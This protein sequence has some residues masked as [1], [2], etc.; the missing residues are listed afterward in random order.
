M[1]YVELTG[2]AFKMFLYLLEINV[3]LTLSWS[4]IT[5]V[6][7]FVIPINS[8]IKKEVP[9]AALLGSWLM[10]LYELKG[11]ILKEFLKG[12]AYFTL[13]FLLVYVATSR[14]LAIYLP[15]ENTRLKLIALTAYSTV[16]AIYLYFPNLYKRI[17]QDLEFKEVIRYF[18]F[19]IA[20][21]LALFLSLVVFPRIWQ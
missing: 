1:S 17:P 7:D 5:F 20:S 11:D 4:L 6:R 19:E 16:M 12:V 2:M 18:T 13:S 3:A 14:I 15:D 8:R 10:T 21:T 9:N